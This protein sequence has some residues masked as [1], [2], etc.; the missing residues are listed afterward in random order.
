MGS[1]DSA[2]PTKPTKPR[3]KHKIA[4]TT[5]AVCTMSI[6]VLPG[7]RSSH[8]NDTGINIAPASARRRS[9]TRRK[10]QKNSNTM[11]V[12]AMTDG[13]WAADGRHIAEGDARDTDGRVH[14]GRFGE[15]GF[16][17]E[18]RRQPFAVQCF[19]ADHGAK[20]FGAVEGAGIDAVK[21]EECAP[22]EEDGVFRERAQAG[23]PTA[24]CCARIDW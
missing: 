13:S 12:A 16:A 4:A 6:L 22:G 18:R 5:H 9:A 19:T 11:P 17:I 3:K 1:E 10:V 24:E 8:K 21:E 7:T 2:H 15:E 20:G 14:A 23:T